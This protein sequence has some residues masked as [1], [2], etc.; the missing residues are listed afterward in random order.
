MSAAANAMGGERFEQEVVALLPDLYGTALR[1]ARNPTDAEDLVAETLAKAWSALDTLND[2]ARFRAWILRILTNTFYADCRARATRPRQEPL[3]DEG[4]AEFSLF[5]KLHQPF[6]LWWG[7]PEKQF[8]ERLL[9]EDLERAVDALP[10]PFR[11]VVVLSDLEGLTYAEIAEALNVPIGTV[12]SRLARGRSILQKVLWEH[13]RDRGL[14]DPRSQQKRTE[15][16]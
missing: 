10:E 13:G 6:L 16:A 2:P 15:P 1:F 3:P 7:N 9:R 5:E 14:V 11:P 8:L 4:C 12:R